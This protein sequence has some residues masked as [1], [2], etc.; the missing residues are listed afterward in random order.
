VKDFP[1]DIFS[2]KRN[3]NKPIDIKKNLEKGYPGRTIDKC[4]IIRM[5]SKELMQQSP[6]KTFL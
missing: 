1:A 5:V 4:T 6:S 3:G 2:M